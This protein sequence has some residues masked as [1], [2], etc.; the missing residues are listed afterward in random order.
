MP[1]VKHQI[2]YA[3]EIDQV[4][5]D[6]SLEASGGQKLLESRELN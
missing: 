4:I 3:T 2:M 6:A 1:Q 5:D